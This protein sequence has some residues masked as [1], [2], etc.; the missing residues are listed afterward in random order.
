[1]DDDDNDD[2]EIVQFDLVNEHKYWVLRIYTSNSFS[3]SVIHL[4]TFVHFYL[5][6]YS[7]SQ[8]YRLISVNPKI[9]TRWGEQ[10]V[11]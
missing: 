6:I 3:S 9:L 5:S 1:V 8:F 10:Y 11:H 7:Q 2:D 4:W